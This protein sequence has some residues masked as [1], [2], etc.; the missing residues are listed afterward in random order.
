MVSESPVAL[1]G[2][3]RGWSNPKPGAPFLPNGRTA[4]R[5][6][7]DKGLI[8]YQAAGIVGN[9]DWES[10]DDPAKTE[11]GDCETCGMGIAQWTGG[12]WDKDRKDNVTWYASQSHASGWDLKT[13]ASTA[14]KGAGDAVIAPGGF[15]VVR[16]CRAVAAAGAGVLRQM[17]GIPRQPGAGVRAGRFQPG[18]DCR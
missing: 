10:H 12:R 17:P 6:F 5:F 7:L 4:Y 1:A 15:R 8:D 2:Q 9:L 18:Q 3:A 14:G 13:P 16:D 11:K